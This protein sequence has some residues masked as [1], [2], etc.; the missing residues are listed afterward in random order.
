MTLHVKMEVPAD[1]ASLTAALE[2]LVRLSQAQLVSGLAGDGHPPLYASRV[3]YRR[4]R[5]GEEDWKSIDRLFADGEGD[6]EDLASARAAQLRHEGEQASAIVVPTRTGKFHAVVLRESGEIED[7]SRILLA[8]EA[9]HMPKQKTKICIRDVGDHCV[10]SIEVPMAGGQKLSAHEVGWDPWAAL[11]KVISSV[12][13]V[14]SDPAVASMLPP[15]AAIALQV[16]ARIADMSPEGL[17]RLLGDDRTTDAQKKLA[18]KVLIAKQANGQG[19]AEV[20]WG[21]TDLAKAAVTAINP[22]A[23]A[24]WITADAVKNAT[25]ARAARAPVVVQ[26]DRSQGRSAQMNPQVPP[27]YPPGYPPPGYPP[28]GYPP[29]GYPPPGYPPQGYPMPPMYGYPPAPM[30]PMPYI[31]PAEMAQFMAAQ[32]QPQGMMSPEEAAAIMMWGAS[33]F[34]PGSFPGFDESGQGAAPQWGGGWGY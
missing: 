1:P 21:L 6:C 17:K 10:G 12:L 15:Q 9:K 28:P 32:Q 30:A 33:A 19:A 20:G 5:P 13:K 34:A 16:A 14:A 7:P 25:Q 4:E 8:M 18:S 11:H 31:D 23:G 3:V 26:R 2:G 22:I 24:T 27:G 29:P